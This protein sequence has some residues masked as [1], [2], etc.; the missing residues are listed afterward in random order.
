MD[1]S[2]LQNWLVPVMGILLAPLIVATV[3]VFRYYV[4][5][6]QHETI[7]LMVEKGMEIPPDL[8]KRK[9]RNAS[10]FGGGF[11]LLGVGIGMLL[12]LGLWHRPFWGL[13]FIF[14]FMGLGG[15]ISVALDRR[16][17]PK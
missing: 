8:L 2:Q 14:V 3:F 12:W 13:G 11:V 17:P 7:R 15:I 1:Q 10:S 16:Y 5:R 4:S 6:Q 9:T